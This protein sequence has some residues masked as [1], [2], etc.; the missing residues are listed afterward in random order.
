MNPST[1]A[2]TTDSNS[3]AP[4]PDGVLPQ[5]TTQP[6]SSGAGVPG[7]KGRKYTP[8]QLRQKLL[9]LGGR[10]ATLDQPA[11]SGFELPASGAL[12][13]SIAD[14]QSK[15]SEIPEKKAAKYT[16]EQW[17]KRLSELGVRDATLD[18]TAPRAFELPASGALPQNQG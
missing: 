7:S 12:P 11:P 4:L 1:P 8:E 2:S 10:D 17:L 18:S 13:K 15:A 14:P 5:S 16:R 6:G 9:D 3:K